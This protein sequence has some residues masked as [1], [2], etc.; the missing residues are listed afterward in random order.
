MISNYHYLKL[1]FLS[2]HFFFIGVQWLGTNCQIKTKPQRWQLPRLGK[3]IFLFS[4]IVF[5]FAELILVAI[6]E[7]RLMN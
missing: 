3:L 7:N 2:V 5:E 6:L 4:N 1:I